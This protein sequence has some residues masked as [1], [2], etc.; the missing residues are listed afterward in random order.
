LTRLRE[1]LRYLA[2]SGVDYVLCVRFD[3][4]FAALTA[5]NFISE[6]LVRVLAC[7][8]SPWVMISALA[9]VVR[10]FLV[11]TEGWAEYGFDVTSTQ[12]FCEGGVRVSSTAVRQAL[13]DDDLCW[14]KRCWAI[15]LHLRTRGAWR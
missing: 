4:R 2:E 6:L 10:G 12:T 7:S 9:L 1:K 14:R 5:Q 11:I 3:R 8:F 13:A 15:R